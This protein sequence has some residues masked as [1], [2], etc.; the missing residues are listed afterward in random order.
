MISLVA[1][2]VYEF[3]QFKLKNARHY[4]TEFWNIVD[5]SLILLYIPTSIVDIL[6]KAP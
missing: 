3:K 6:F 5:I 2:V 4:V 1:L